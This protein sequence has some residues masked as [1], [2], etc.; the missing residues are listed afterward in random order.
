MIII[1]KTQNNGLKDYKKHFKLNQL[2][3]ISWRGHHGSIE[4]RDIY[5]EKELTSEEAQNYV[6]MT[7]DLLYHDL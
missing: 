6:K 5:T 7:Y 4:E 2:V 1:S 3:S